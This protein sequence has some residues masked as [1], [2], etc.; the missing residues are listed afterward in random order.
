LRA[1]PAKALPQIGDGRGCA[2]PY[3][4]FMAAA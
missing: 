1:M 3:R 2:L 4:Q